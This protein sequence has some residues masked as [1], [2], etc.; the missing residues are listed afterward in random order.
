MSRTALA[1]FLTAFMATPADQAVGPDG[2]DYAGTVIGV[3]TDAETQRPVGGAQVS[4]A[5][6][7]MG[8]LTQRDGSYAL[9]EVPEEGRYVMTLRHACY[10]TVSVEVELSQTHEQPLV[11]HVGL[12]RQPRNTL[13]PFSEPLGGCWQWKI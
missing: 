7:D 8:G 4:F 6:L 10:L 3:I 13:L 5:A 9:Y 2:D 11:V 1:V 12:P